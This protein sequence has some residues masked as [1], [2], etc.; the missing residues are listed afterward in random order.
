MVKR[1]ISAS[2]KIVGGVAKVSAGNG[3]DTVAAQWNRATACGKQ[4]HLGLLHN[5]LVSS[6]PASI[7]TV[8]QV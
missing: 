3:W 1:T 4:Q 5:M 6:K 7:V 2:A 8:E